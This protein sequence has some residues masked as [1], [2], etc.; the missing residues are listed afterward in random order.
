MHATNHASSIIIVHFAILEY[1]SSVIQSGT[2]NLISA[3]ID[4]TTITQF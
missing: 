3:V 4:I 1:T 2:S